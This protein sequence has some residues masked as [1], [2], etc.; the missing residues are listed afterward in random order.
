MPGALRYFFTHPQIDAGVRLWG[1]TLNGEGILLSRND[2]VGVRFRG[3]PT[4]VSRRS[5]WT[6]ADPCGGLC[7]ALSRVLLPRW[8]DGSVRRALLYAFSQ[9]PLTCQ[10]VGR[11]DGH[12]CAGATESFRL[13]L[14]ASGIGGRVD[15]LTFAEP[16][17]GF[18]RFACFQ[19][20]FGAHLRLGAFPI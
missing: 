4:R 16:S 10:D 11:F 1:I 17:S 8:P 15:F 19:V 5:A 20:H 6:K 14:S 2:S 18:Q 3:S 12:R 13:S 7:F 9:R